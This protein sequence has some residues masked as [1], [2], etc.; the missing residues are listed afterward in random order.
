M[1]DRDTACG[2]TLFMAEG[3]GKWCRLEV[4]IEGDGLSPRDV[5]V[6]H[7]AELLQ[8]TAAAVEAVAQEEGVDPPELRLVEMRT[9]LAAYDL[10]SKHPDASRV[11]RG[12]YQAAKTRGKKNGAPVRHALS[13]MH[14]ASRIGS[15]RIV[16]QDAK[17]IPRAK[18]IHLAPPLEGVTATFEA[19]TEIHGRVVGVLI[20]RGERTN[21]RIRLDGGGTDDFEADAGVADSAARLFGR[22]VAATVTYEIG[23]DSKIAGRIENVTEWDNADLLDVLR[24][25]REELADSGIEVDAGAWLDALDKAARD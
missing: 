17:G 23:E 13:R 6:R 10:L 5:N 4:A 12:L 2:Y 18:P 9:G 22:N 19:A 3:R 14:H 20:G 25:A 24:D 8:A 21:V 15:I 7:L 11:F 16:P 1:L